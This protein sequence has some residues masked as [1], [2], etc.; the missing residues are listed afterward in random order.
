[1]KSYLSI[2]LVAFTLI[3]CAHSGAA[4][5][6]DRNNQPVKPAFFDAVKQRVHNGDLTA[7]S[8]LAATNSNKAI[9]LLLQYIAPQDQPDD[10]V[11]LAVGDALVKMHAEKDIH[12]SI[13]N[14]SKTG[15]SADRERLLAF[16]TLSFMRSRASVRA[17]ASFLDDNANKATTA[18][19]LAG[20]NC[21]S[22]VYA[23]CRM[24]LLNAPNKA[25]DYQSLSFDSIDKWRQWWKLNL[26]KFQGDGPLPTE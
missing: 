3:V 7:F 15:E 16:M 19:S 4:Q 23:L 8:D 26:G 20:A 14:Y 13:V 25:A 22:S 1:M 17:I 11:A 6:A 10:P 12:K 18:S 21:E 24:N 9:P 2:P 5:E